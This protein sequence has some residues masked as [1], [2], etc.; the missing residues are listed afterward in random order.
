[1]VNTKK[2][3]CANRLLDEVF[4]DVYK[5][6]IEKSASIYIRFPKKTLKYMVQK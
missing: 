3:I 4:D 2:N 5:K 1:M 6:N